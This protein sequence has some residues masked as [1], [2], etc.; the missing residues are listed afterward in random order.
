MDITTANSKALRRSD[1][2]PEKIE[3]SGGGGL[4]LLRVEEGCTTLQSPRNALGDKR[5][6]RNVCLQNGNTLDLGLLGVKEAVI[7][8]FNVVF[9]LRHHLTQPF[10][11]ILILGHVLPPRAPSWHRPR[12]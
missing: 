6:H 10:D 11:F 8:L 9:G 3:H 2:Q 1:V 4:P 7:E 12:Y 5:E